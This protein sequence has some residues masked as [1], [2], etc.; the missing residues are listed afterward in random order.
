MGV[1]VVLSRLSGVL[2]SDACERMAPHAFADSLVITVSHLG[3]LIAFCITG[4]SE[5]GGCVSG[6]SH[7]CST[8][9]DSPLKAC[10]DMLA[11]AGRP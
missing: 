9:S 11:Q 2:Q 6:S 7:T 4:L 5:P 1:F 3:W 8:S 10:P